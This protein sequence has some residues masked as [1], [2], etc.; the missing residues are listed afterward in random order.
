MLFNIYLKNHMRQ[1]AES[2]QRLLLFKISSI[3]FFF[4]QQYTYYESNQLMQIE[5]E[6][7]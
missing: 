6:A 4:V 3:F 2:G 7:R 5:A 1:N